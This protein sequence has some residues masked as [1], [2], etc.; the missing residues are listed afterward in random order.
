MKFLAEYI[1]REGKEDKYYRTIWADSLNEATKI[2]NKYARKGFICR[3]TTQ[4][5]GE[6]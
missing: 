6:D 1:H 5:E 2:S 3:H 4:K